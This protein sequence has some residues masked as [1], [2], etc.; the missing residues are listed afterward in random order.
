M[1]NTQ[2]KTRYTFLKNLFVIFIPIFYVSII[3]FLEQMYKNKYIY[4]TLSRIFLQ[5]IFSFILGLILIYISNY[6]YT[7]QNKRANKCLVIGLSFC[8]LYNLFYFVSLITNVN[9]H[10]IVSFTR[11]GN[12][13]VCFLFIGFYSILLT[14]KKRKDCCL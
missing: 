4:A 2:N 13:K 11:Y 7:T 10:F 8:I 1:R 5:S 6:V 9:F 14:M 12:F 3:P